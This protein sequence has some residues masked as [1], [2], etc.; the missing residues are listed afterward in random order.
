LGNATHRHAQAPQ[1]LNALSQAGI[2]CG[3]GGARSGT[4]IN[5]A[6]Q[7]RLNEAIAPL[8]GS[9]RGLMPAACAAGISPMTAMRSTSNLR[10]SKV[11]LA[12]LWLFIRQVPSVK[13]K[14]GN[15]S[16]PDLFG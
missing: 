5:Q 1:L 4:A 7:A 10:P 12:F 11:S 14:R 15:S 8:A 6:I 13:F 16:F 9:A 3:S 2:D